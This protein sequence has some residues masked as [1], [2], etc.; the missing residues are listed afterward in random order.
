MLQTQY[1]VSVWLSS[2]TDE[3]T[4]Q[5]YLNHGFAAASGLEEVDTDFIEALCYTPPLHLFDIIDKVSF[6]KYFR[7]E[8]VKMLYPQQF[9]AYSAAIFVYARKDDYSTINARVFEPV[10][11]IPASGKLFHVGTIPFEIPEAEK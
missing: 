11:F 6:G 8:C 3:N 7:S 4:L 10:R 5:D 2:H 1:A 9:S